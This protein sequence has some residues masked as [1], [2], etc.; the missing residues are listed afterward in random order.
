MEWTDG[1]KYTGE[2]NA[3]MMHGWGTLSTLD[4]GRL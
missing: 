4:R 1:T 3:G 2:W